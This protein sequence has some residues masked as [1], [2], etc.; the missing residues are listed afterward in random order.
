MSFIIPINKIN[1]NNNSNNNVITNQIFKSINIDLKKLLQQQEKL[2]NFII[3]PTRKL[4][5]IGS[6]PK[7]L[8]IM[9]KQCRPEMVETLKLEEYQDDIKEFFFLFTGI[10][11]I[12]I[13]NL[14]TVPTFPSFWPS[15]SELYIT[16]KD[17][18]PLSCDIQFP[19][20]LQVLYLR[21]QQ[22]VNFSTLDLHHHSS[23]TKLSIISDI[24]QKIEMNKI[25]FPNST[26]LLKYL[27]LTLDFNPQDCRSITFPPNLDYFGIT[28]FSLDMDGADTLVPLPNNITHL[29][30]LNCD[31]RLPDN[32]FPLSLRELVLGRG[33]ISNIPISC[34]PNGTIEKLHFTKHIGHVDPKEYFKD[35]ITDL[36]I[37]VHDPSIPLGLPRHLVKLK[38][39]LGFPDFG[40]NPPHYPTTLDSLEYKYYADYDRSLILY[41][42]TSITKLTCQMMSSRLDNQIYSLPSTKIFNNNNINNSDPNHFILPSNINI[43]SVDIPTTTNQNEDFMIQIDQIINSSNV[44]VLVVSKEQNTRFE[45]HIKRLEMDNKYVMITEKHSFTGGIIRQHRVESNHGLLYNPSFM[46]FKKIDS[47]YIVKFG[48]SISN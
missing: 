24:L 48:K 37:F 8:S 23:L 45:F 31:Y 42:P 3:P 32:Y 20:T 2:T 41:I 16:T 47:N 36:C 21:F 39:H 35:S 10:K 43:L 5:V 6:L 44:K 14:S 33:N 25:L 11:I 12:K 29:K 18:F 7:D 19:L 30:I 40:I 4:K 26:G 46:I 38:I 9:E 1:F 13:E 28:T 22:N 15:L 17:V 34:I 27:Q